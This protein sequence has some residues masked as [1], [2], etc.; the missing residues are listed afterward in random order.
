MTQTTKCVRCGKSAKMWTGYVLKRFGK[1]VLAGWCS[2]NCNILWN[3][4]YGPFKKK[5]GEEQ[6]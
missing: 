5:H 6:A 2:N 1:K 4:Y 3:A